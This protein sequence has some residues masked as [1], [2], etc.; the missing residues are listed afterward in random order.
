MSFKWYLIMFMGCSIS[1]F[2]CASEPDKPVPIRERVGADCV[3]C[4]HACTLCL[5]GWTVLY[6]MFL[7]SD[8]SRCD[9]KNLNTSCT[10]VL[11]GVVPAHGGRGSIGRTP[12]IQELF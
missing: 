3:A 2:N 7:I 9:R 1:T 5:C 8:V 10:H 11:P 4:F 12:N 6:N